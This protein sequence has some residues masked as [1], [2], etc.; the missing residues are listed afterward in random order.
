MIDLKVKVFRGKKG[1]LALYD[2][3]LKIWRI[4]I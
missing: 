3:E 2:S 4:L 1:K